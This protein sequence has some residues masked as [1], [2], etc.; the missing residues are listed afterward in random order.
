MSQ[1]TNRDIAS[2]ETGNDTPQFRVPP[3]EHRFVKGKSGN[4][5]G[6]PKKVKEVQQRVEDLVDDAVTVLAKALKDDDAKVRLAA[7]NAILDRGLGKPKQAV[8]V[9]ADVTNHNGT[10]PVSDTARWIED[11][12]RARADREAEKSM[13][14]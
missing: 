7:A 1:E 11:T 5:G 9:K 8:E 3:V 6:R 13:P 14:N 2:P 12:L 10:E 4:P